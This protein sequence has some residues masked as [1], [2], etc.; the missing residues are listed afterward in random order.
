MTP[1]SVFL[2]SPVT[3]P[4]THSRAMNAPSL[5]AQTPWDASRGC[6]VCVCSTDR[7]AWVQGPV[8]PW[9]DLSRPARPQNENSCDS[10]QA[11]SISVIS[12]SGVRAAWG[13]AGVSASL[14]G[15]GEERVGSTGPCRVGSGKSFVSAP[16]SCL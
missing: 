4:P 11:A 5:R 13:R 2:S 10:P 3:V 16:S 14:G 15:W 6:L 12:L 9:M 7:M 8:G 1:Y